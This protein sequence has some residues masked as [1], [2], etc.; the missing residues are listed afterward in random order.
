MKLSCEQ[1]ESALSDWLAEEIDATRA[2]ALD[3]HL[4]ACPACREKAQAQMSQHFALLQLAGNRAQA[5]LRGQ[6][7]A[8]LRTEKVVA[9][10]A[11]AARFQWPQWA[12]VAAAIALLAGTMFWFSRPHTGDFSLANVGD[13]DG[14]FAA[15]DLARNGWRMPSDPLLAAGESSLQVAG[16]VGEIESMLKP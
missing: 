13:L 14:V 5:E 12:A 8:A 11:P 4:A 3:A 7:R 2:E 10:P 9:F 1:I 6:V 15:A 16:L